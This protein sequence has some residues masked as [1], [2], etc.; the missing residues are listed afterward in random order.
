MPTLDHF[1]TSAKT[2]YRM[3]L[4]PFPFSASGPAWELIVLFSVQGTRMPR[5][6]VHF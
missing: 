6:S 5:L 1:C 4:F 2:L 3:D